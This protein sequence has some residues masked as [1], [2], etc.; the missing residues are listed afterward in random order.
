MVSRWLKLKPATG[1]EIFQFYLVIH[2]D[3]GAKS[4]VF[5]KY[6][7]NTMGKWGGGFGGDICYLDWK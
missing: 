5:V 2:N 1:T 6:D 4:Y 3:K 7:V